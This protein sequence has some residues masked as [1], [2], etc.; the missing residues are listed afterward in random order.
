M[1]GVKRSQSRDEGLEAMTK[2]FNPLVD[3]KIWQ[4]CE[5]PAHKISLGG[6]WF[7]AL[8]K[9]ENGEI[10]RYKASYVAK[11]FNQVFGSDFSETFAPTAKL[12]SIRMLLAL[13]T[14]FQCEVFQF[15]VSSAYLNADLEE[16][17]YVEQ[18][19]DF[20]IPGKGS[21]LLCKLLKGLHGVK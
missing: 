3:N 10:V 6:R 18:P 9:D 14:K 1:E 11:G 15:Y 12:S 8:N 13:A 21:K 4:L 17:V 2:E 20:E 19:P 7:F 5:L 16:D